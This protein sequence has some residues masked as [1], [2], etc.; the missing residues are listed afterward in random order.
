MRKRMNV[1][2]LAAACRGRGRRSATSVGRS[3]VRTPHAAA[4]RLTLDTYLEMETV[5]DP[6]LSPDGSQIIYTRGWIDKMNDKPRVGALD[7]E[8]RRHAATASSSRARA[9]SGRRR[10]PDRA[11]PRRASRTGSQIFVRWMDA[12]GAT[13]QVTHVEQ[14]P[15]AIAWSPDGKQL[16]FTMLVEERNTWPI[17]MPK[18]PAGAKWTEA[19]RIVERLNYRA[20]PHGLHRQ[21]LPPHLRRPGDGGTPRQITSGKFDHTGSEWTPDGKE[22]PLQR[23]ARRERRLPVARVGDLRGRRRRPA[24]SGSSPRATDPT[25]TRRSRRTASAIAY[26]G[27]DYTHATPGP[28]KLY[29]MNIDGSNPRLRARPTG[30]ARRRPALGA[31]RQRRSTSPR[32]T[33]GR[34]TSTTCR[35]P[36]DAAKVHAGD[37]GRAHAGGLAT[38]RQGRRGRH[39]DQ[40]S[41]KP[42]D[43]VVVRPRSPGDDQAAHRVNDDVLRARSSATSRRSGTRRSTA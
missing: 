22:H 37:Q 33:K 19:P 11:T 21:R 2:V 16:S 41:Q 5:S 24:T 29:V 38:S 42:G 32:R 25:A 9:R 34:R 15:S 17:K 36:L 23:P 18:A 43:I 4:D 10:R 8:R 20:R 31:R 40:P 6:Q 28:T 27:Y 1:L 12:E 3:S 7:H 14:R 26:T 39:A 13:T 35:S 30:T